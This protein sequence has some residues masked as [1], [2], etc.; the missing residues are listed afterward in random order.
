MRGIPLILKTTTTRSSHINSLVDVLHRWSTESPDRDAC[1][2]LSFSAAPDRGVTYHQLGAQARAV[3]AA[4]Q[5]RVLIGLAHMHHF[6]GRHVEV[7]VCADEALSLGREA[8]D[9]WAVSFA[10]FMQALAALN[11]ATTRRLPR[12]LWRRETR[13]MPPTR[14]SV[15]A[16]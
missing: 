15:P 12:V 13:P 11:W 10:L 9:A 14:Y 5:A 6:Q 16:L 1:R 3:G 7:R 8:G 4:L 2:F